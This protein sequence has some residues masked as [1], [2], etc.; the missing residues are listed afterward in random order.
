MKR[1]VAKTAKRA[2]APQHDAIDALVAASA[3]ALGLTIDPAWEA[4]V[5]SNLQL[6][7]SHA[8]RVDAFPLA[9]ETEPAPIFHA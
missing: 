1:K 4:S 3:Q 8:A 5:K 6:I 2:A 9:D 7:F